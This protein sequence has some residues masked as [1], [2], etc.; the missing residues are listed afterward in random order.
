MPSAKADDQKPLLLLEVQW[1]LYLNLGVVSQP[2]PGGGLQ[3]LG[4]AAQG[5]Y[6]SR[7]DMTGRNASHHINVIA[8]HILQREVSQN[9]L[10][11]LP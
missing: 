9:C 7:C 8:T 4:F 2:Q 5:K 11:I 6:F 1:E 3:I 10:P